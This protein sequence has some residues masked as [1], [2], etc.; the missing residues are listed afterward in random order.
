MLKKGAWENPCSENYGGV[1]S[2]KAAVYWP[3]FLLAIY[4]ATEIFLKLPNC[5]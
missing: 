3:R 1:H 5:Y 4:S 2:G